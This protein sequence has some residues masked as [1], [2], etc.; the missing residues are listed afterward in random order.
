LHEVAVLIIS[1]FSI[2]HFGQWHSTC[3]CWLKQK[4]HQTWQEIYLSTSEDSSSVVPT[5]FS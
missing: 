2:W 5:A 1:T 3:V 4:L